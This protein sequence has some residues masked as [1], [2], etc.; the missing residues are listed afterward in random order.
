MKGIDSMKR[1][2]LVVLVLGVACWARATAVA[3]AA[4]SICA[5]DPF[6]GTSGVGHVTPATATC[7]SAPRTSPSSSEAVGIDG[8]VWV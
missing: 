3:F 6:I 8:W 4:D 1:K 5:V 7:P 2:T